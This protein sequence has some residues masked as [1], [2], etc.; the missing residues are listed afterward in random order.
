MEHRY[1][2]RN[3]KGLGFVFSMIASTHM[4]NALSIVAKQRASVVIPCADTPQ[5]NEAVDIASDA[6]A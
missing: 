4:L 6:Q 3:L 2:K 1:S 5:H